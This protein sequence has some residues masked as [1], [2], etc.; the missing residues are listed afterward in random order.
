MHN[1]LDLRVQDMILRFRRDEVPLCLLDREDIIVH[2]APTCVGVFTENNSVKKHTRLHYVLII[3]FWKKFAL[4][5]GRYLSCM[6]S[7]YT[8]FHSV[9]G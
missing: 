3:Q 2:I 9:L 1:S 7:I 6:Q 8:R 4:K 5:R